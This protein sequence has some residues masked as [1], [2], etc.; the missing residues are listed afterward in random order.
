[1]VSD[2]TP[3]PVTQ[4]TLKGAPYVTVS[5]VGLAQGLPRNNNANYGPD[6]PGTVTSGIQEAI[7]YTGT[8][9]GGVIMLLPG[10]FTISATLVIG[11]PNIIITGSGIPSGVKL[12]IGETPTNTCVVK[13]ANSV[14][15]SIILISFN[16]AS[17]NGSAGFRGCIIEKLT[18]DG[19]GANQTSGNGIDCAAADVMLRDIEIRDVKSNGFVNYSTNPPDGGENNCLWNC[20][21]HDCG[22]NGVLAQHADTRI[23]GGEYFGNGGAGINVTAGAGGFEC[24]EANIYANA[25]GMVLSANSGSLE[26]CI[27]AGTD[28]DSN[29]NYGLQLLAT[30]NHIS[31]TTFTGC[32][33]WNNSTGPGS[34]AAHVLVD[35]SVDAV[36][37]GCTFNQASGS[38]YN[39]LAG[40]MIETLNALGYGISVLGCTFR[41]ANRAIS[42]AFSPYSNI[43]DCKGYNPQGFGVTTPAFPTTG[44]NVQNN[45]PFPVRIYLLSAGTG[46]GF[47]ITDPSGTAQ[48]VTVTLAAGMEF[49]LD[50]GASIQF[51]YTIAPTWKWYG[52]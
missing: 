22:S 39:N 46:T 17:P 1:M 31:G 41:N 6:T 21:I 12:S 3:P 29:A 33:F 38:P 28:F 40:E 50:P 10:K 16:G 47:T 49:T 45:N 8:N 4:A 42:N 48:A 18:L 51:A 30:T 26:H 19:N 32:T 11:N 20:F 5:P 44:T 24:V 23:V 52:V 37:S 27:I 7:G 43:E 13:L 9:G 2:Y 14:N 36:F 35:G 25:N 15:G 34:S